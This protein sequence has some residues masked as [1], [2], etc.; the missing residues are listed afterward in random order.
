MKRLK[1]IAIGTAIAAILY[2][3]LHVVIFDFSSVAVPFDEENYGGKQVAIGPKPRWW[4]PKASH[5]L[6]IP[7]G[8]DFD[9][10]G[11]PFI[12][13]KPICI[14]YVKSE[15]YALPAAWR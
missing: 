3:I 9:T 2:L 7:G 4:V 13:W 5:G 6:D 1:K 15:G 10:T 8:Y 11:W 14:W 12:V